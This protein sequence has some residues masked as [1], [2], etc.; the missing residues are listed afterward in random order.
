MTIKIALTN[1]GKY[2]EGTLVYTWL[3]LPATDEE[4]QAAFEEIEVKNGTEYEE[5]F[6]SDYEAPAGIEIGEYSN[7]D[8]L[9]ALAEKLEEIDSFETIASG[10]YGAGDV[11]N[12]AREL[13]DLGIINDAYEHI[14]DIVSDEELDDMVQE[15]AKGGWQG[16][17]CF[18]A[19]IDYMNDDYY[20]INGYANAENL[21]TDILGSK[22]QD[23]MRA[24]RDWI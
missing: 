12:L 22:V 23:L 4:I 18:L 14:G 7:I 17:A 1:L 16:V 9:N 11:L 10:T 6:I 3:D 13:E 8:T 21:T 24:I 20:Y 15:R 5:H 2:N 19:K